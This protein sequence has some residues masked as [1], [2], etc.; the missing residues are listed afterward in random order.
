M[1]YVAAVEIL[2]PGLDEPLTWSSTPA[3]VTSTD[4][5][6]VTVG[7]GPQTDVFVDPQTG[8][9][10]A[11]AARALAPA[12]DGDFPMSARVK[13]GFRSTFDATARN[14]ASSSHLKVCRPSFR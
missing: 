7:S 14:S 8:E 2:V 9:V 5:G 10:T 3:D 4:S 13:V 11:S 12:P 6:A 1:E